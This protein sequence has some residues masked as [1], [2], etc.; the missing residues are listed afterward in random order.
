M[1][2]YLANLAFFESIDL[3]SPKLQEDYNKAIKWPDRA[4]DVIDV[5]VDKFLHHTAP[6]LA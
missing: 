2:P 6:L 4:T 5:T 1:D 3:S